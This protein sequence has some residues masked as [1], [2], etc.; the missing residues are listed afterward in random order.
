MEAIFIAGPHFITVIF[1]HFLGL[2]TLL[3][4]FFA[5]E[6]KIAPVTLAGWKETI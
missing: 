4:T 5:E 2:V 6:A 1:Q 3:V